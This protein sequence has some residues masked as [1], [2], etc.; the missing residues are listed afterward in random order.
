MSNGYMEA[1]GSFIVR[2]KEIKFREGTTWAI[3][4][5]PKMGAYNLRNA[6]T[7]FSKWIHFAQ[8]TQK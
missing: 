4:Q 1:A 6:F 5:D 3:H 2:N 7:T 8:K